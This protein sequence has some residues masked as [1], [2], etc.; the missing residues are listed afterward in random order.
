MYHAWSYESKMKPEAF[1]KALYSGIDTKPY[2][3]KS[4]VYAPRTEALNLTAQYRLGRLYGLYTDE[5]LELLRRGRAPVITKGEH[6]GQ[7]AHVD[8]IL[9]MS[10]YPELE[11]SMANLR[12][13]P[14]KLNMQKSDTV[15]NTAK[16][17]ARDLREEVGWDINVKSNTP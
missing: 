1:F 2:A 16:R 11:N 15:T 9:P 3:N 14:A 10:K 5:N 7:K 8:H 4:H 17:R 6:Q 13:M 12:W